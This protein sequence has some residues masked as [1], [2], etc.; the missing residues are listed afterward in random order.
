MGA[1]GSGVT[2]K[3]CADFDGLPAECLCRDHSGHAYL[4]CSTANAWSQGKARC[5]FSQMSLVKI[6]SAGEDAWILKQAHDISDPRPLTFFWI[7]ASS[8]DSPG[9][10]HWSDG[11]TFWL[12][13]ANGS[14]VG[15]SYFNWRIS[16]PQNTQSAA[17]VFMDDNGWEEGDCSIKRGYVCEAQE[18]Q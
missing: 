11:A 9:T 3:A 10:W 14:P 17:C 12:G 5:G 4:F 7:G 1:G 15:S 16:N 13:D 2:P 6:E 8:V 18:T